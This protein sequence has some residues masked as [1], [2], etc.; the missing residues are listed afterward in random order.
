[1]VAMDFIQWCESTAGQVKFILIL[2]YIF[3]FKE[4]LLLCVVPSH[5]IPPKKLK[6]CLLNDDKV[7]K[8]PQSW[9]RRGG[10]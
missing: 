6:L 10:C 5:K 3:L 2:G 9:G 1:M 7:W 4:Q 8:V